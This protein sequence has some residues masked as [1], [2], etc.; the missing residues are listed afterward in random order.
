MP[1]ARTR[2]RRLVPALLRR[3]QTFRRYWTGQTISLF[4]DEVTTIAL[5]LTAVLVLHAGAAEMGFLTASAWVPYLLLSYVAGALVDRLGRRRQVMIAAD[6]GRALALGSIPVAY[7][8]HGLTLAQLYAVALTAGTLSALFSVA[9]SS[10]FMSIVARDD[11]VD[12]QSLVNGSRAFALMAGPS[13]GGFITQLVSA[14]AAIFADAVSFLG[15]ASF[16]LRIRPAEAPAA[17]G[18]SGAMRAGARYIRHSAVVRSALAC[19]AV[20]N[21]FNF[22]FNAIYTLFAV[23]SLQV[24]PATLGLILAAGAAGSVL[25]AVLTRRV[26]ARIGIG[27]AYLVGCVLFTVPLVLVPL[28]GGARALILAMLFAAEFLS[29]LG[30]MLL[31]ISIGS[32]FAA[33]IPH[34]LRSRVS[35]AYTTV[36]YGVRPIGA[37]FGGFLGAA[38]GLRFALL[39]A[40]VGASVGVVFA[41]GPAIRRMQRLPAVATPALTP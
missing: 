40:T 23:R 11:F 13:L 27:P 32:I 24:Q 15:S 25:G 31:D 35:G 39:V 6:I 21:F 33:V 5:P 18:E 12:A 29:G 26:A 17:R 1:G 20:I 19:T 4:G 28:A 41:L 16:L 37:V 3:Q 2:A 34:S 14:P 36:N 9:Q 38:V 22:A 8:L 10:L 7:L 30:V